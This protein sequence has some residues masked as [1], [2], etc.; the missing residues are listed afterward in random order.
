MSGRFGAWVLRERASRTVRPV[1]AGDSIRARDAAVVMRDRRAETGRVARGRNSQGPL[2]AGGECISGEGN[3]RGAGASVTPAGLR[4]AASPHFSPSRA[5]GHLVRG[6]AE[7]KCPA[8]R[9]LR[10]LALQAQ[11]EHEPRH[12]GVPDPNVQHPWDPTT[13]IQQPW[14]DNP[15]P[16]TLVRQP[17]D[18]HPGRL[19]CIPYRQIRTRSRE[20][21][22]NRGQIS[23]TNGSA[24]ATWYGVEQSCS[25]MRFLRPEHP[26]RNTNE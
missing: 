26:S 24:S 12:A 25:I 21:P 8:A 19:Q 22:R 23:P 18:R 13:G 6:G 11:G 16:T 5:P 7:R 17:R 10:K 2:R 20:P 1:E 3:V 4:R 15:G 14:S 9:L